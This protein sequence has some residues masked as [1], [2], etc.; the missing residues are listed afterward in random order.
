MSRQRV[1]S[2]KAL[3]ANKVR[4]DSGD[5]HTPELRRHDKIAG[6]LGA[7]ALTLGV[8]AALGTPAVAYAAPTTNSGLHGTTAQFGHEGGGIGEDIIFG[9][10][11]GGI[12]QHTNFG[13]EG[14]GIAQHTNFG[15]EGGG[16][17]Q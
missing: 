12:A 6:W 10:E 16:I 14:G 8:G 17:A 15:H 5:R 13:H 11:G 3:Q 2:P 4:S 7:G 1:N 9:H